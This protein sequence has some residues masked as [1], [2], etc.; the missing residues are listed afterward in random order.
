[1][2]KT[3]ILWICIVV[4]CITGIIMIIINEN[5]T[6]TITYPDGC[7]E[8]WQRGELQ[9]E[10]ICNEGRAIENNTFPK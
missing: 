8:T 7:K 6:E 10:F 2:D 9:S 1:M 5:T 3:L 4:I